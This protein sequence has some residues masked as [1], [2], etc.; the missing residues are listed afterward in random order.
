MKQQKQLSS[1]FQAEKFGKVKNKRFISQWR[2][3]I[4]GSNSV[5]STIN[6]SCSIQMCWFQGLCVVLNGSLALPEILQLKDTINEFSYTSMF[7]L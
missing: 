7:L 3:H 1:E 2:V 6:N 4:Q 5:S